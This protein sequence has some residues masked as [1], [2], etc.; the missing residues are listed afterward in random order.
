M[1]FNQNVKFNS[2]YYIKIKYLSYNKADWE[3]QQLLSQ[4]G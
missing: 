2:D 3:K 4:I 1:I